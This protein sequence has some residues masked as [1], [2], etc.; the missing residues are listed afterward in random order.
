MKQEFPLPVSPNET[1]RP[2]AQK[3]PACRFVADAAV[4]PCANDMQFCFT[5]GALQSKQQAIIEQRWMIDA[6]IV[7]DERIAN[8][9]QLQQAISV[10]I[11]SG[12]TRD[13]KAQHNP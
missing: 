2:Y 12:Q 6:I 10:R 1:H 11:V 7:P 8:A 3:P 9:A 4:E 5:H 13:F